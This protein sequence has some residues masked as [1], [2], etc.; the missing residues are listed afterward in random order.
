M[1]TVPQGMF[2]G[3]DGLD[4]RNDLSESLQEEQMTSHD[5][6]GGEW[7]DEWK[8]PPPQSLAAPCLSSPSPH[9]P[10]PKHREPH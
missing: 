6:L 1:A 3:Q 2:M 10:A 8:G 9:C 5:V 4:P 7:R